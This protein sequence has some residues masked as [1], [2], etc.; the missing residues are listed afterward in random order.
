MTPPALSSPPRMMPAF[1][2]PE[3]TPLCRLQVN[4][5]LLLTADRWQLAHA[6]HRQRQNIHYQAL[7]QG[8]IVC[9][10]GVGVIM[11][12]AELPPKYQDQR[13]VRVQP[14]IA[15]DA[16]GNPI[17][18]PQAMDYRIAARPQQVQMVYLVVSY[19][20][21]DRLTTDP[22]HDVIQET[23]RIDEKTTPPQAGEVE[24][25]RLLLQPPSIQLANPYDLFYPEANQLDLRHR[26]PAGPKPLSLIQVAQLARDDGERE[27]A[28]RRF[29]ALFNALDGL[30][31]KL[32]AV[33]AVPQF[34]DIALTTSDLAPAIADLTL[35]H[36]TYENLL[37]LPDSQ[38]TALKHYLSRGG[39]LMVEVATDL[40]Q[41][42]E[43]TQLH[44]E[45]FEALQ[46]LQAGQKLPELQQQLDSELA[47]IK[48]T[49]EAEVNSLLQ[50]LT[51]IL[52]AV[53]LS[54][55]GSG[56]VERWHPL[57]S[58]PFRFQ[59]WPQCDGK[60]IEVLSWGGIVLVVGR[61]SSHWGGDELWLER[62]TLRAAQ[63]L[64]INL[65]QF[66]QQRQQLHQGLTPGETRRQPSETPA[67]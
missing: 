57:R 62:G 5:G 31:P 7:N 40:T 44:R 33:K 61:L 15:I 3:I 48:G 39:V 66:A 24:L 20:D 67:V 14:G 51:T 21:P 27:D 12:P 23:F 65:L 41:I 18:V 34:A 30:Y 11:P 59:Q 53:G 25:C 54:P 50:P 1:P 58:R 52:A 35:V 26:H 28:T 45:L 4:D 49:S 16:T 56:E 46:L 2:T 32:E 37:R 9:G 60:P 43:L 38:Q 36:S 63:E 19:V 64:G 42:D 55:S 10:L 13:W 47:L 29:I 17:V 22:S 8:G 6:Y